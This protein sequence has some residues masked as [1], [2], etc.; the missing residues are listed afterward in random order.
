LEFSSKP[1]LRPAGFVEPCIPTLADQPLAGLAWL[2][3]IKH[4]G[5]RLMVWR[6]AKSSQVVRE[7]AR[8]LAWLG[9]D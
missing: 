9:Y 2:H 4:D 7:G 3:E 1:V 8:S 6:E 5:Y